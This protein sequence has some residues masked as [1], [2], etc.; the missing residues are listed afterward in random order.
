MTCPPCNHDCNQGRTCP[1]RQKKE[2]PPMIRLF[3]AITA[4]LVSAYCITHPQ[5]VH[6]VNNVAHTA[7]NPY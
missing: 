3:L 7:D 6:N 1:L 5:T 4:A 2:T